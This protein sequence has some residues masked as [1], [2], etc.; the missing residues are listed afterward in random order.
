[1]RGQHD[2]SRESMATITTTWH[3][4]HA[5][6]K[7]WCLESHKQ[8][9]LP[10]DLGWC[11]RVTRARSI[12]LQERPHPN[13]PHL[14]NL[15]PA[16]PNTTLHRTQGKHR[17][18]HIRA[19]MASTCKMMPALDCAASCHNGLGASS[20]MRHKLPHSTKGR[21]TTMA[22]SRRNGHSTS[23]QPDRLSTTRLQRHSLGLGAGKL[24]AGAPRAISLRLAANPQSR[25][26]CFNH[27]THVHSFK[28]GTEPKVSRKT[29]T[30]VT[31]NPALPSTAEVEA[32]LLS[33]RHGNFLTT[34]SCDNTHIP[35]CV[36][37]H[38]DMAGAL[39]SSN[40]HCTRRPHAIEANALWRGHLVRTYS[41]R[42]ECCLDCPRSR[43]ILHANLIIHTSHQVI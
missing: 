41:A 42:G 6:V 5:A 11:H 15:R 26:P 20:T 38:T 9:L 31:I 7:V 10:H 30:N 35:S 27:E 17:P 39:I 14:E 4:I 28:K 40:A 34:F 23:R 22:P 8:P 29:S 19:E 3:H 25:Q 43:A 33:A 21:I 24:V 13:A 37:S 32:R 36:A 16:R 18:S 1:M 12:L 2:S